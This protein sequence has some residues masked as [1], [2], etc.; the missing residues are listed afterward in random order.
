M[1]SRLLLLG[2]LLLAACASHEPP[3]PLDRFLAGDLDAMRE[4]FDREIR[5]GNANSG[6][7]YLNQLAGMELLDGRLESARKKF[8]AAGRFMNNDN[9]SGSEEF[10]AIWGAESS[11]AW[12]GDPYEKAM[13]GY[14][15]GILYW[16]ADQPDNGRA[17]FRRGLNA[18]SE[19]EG[20]KFQNDFALLFWLAG[21]ASVRMG[22]RDD[23]EAYFRQASEAQVFAVTHGA[24]GNPEARI[25]REPARGNLICLVDMGLGP[26]KY[27]D[28]SDGELARFRARRRPEAQAEVFLGGQSLGRTE[29]LVDVPYQA[30]TRGGTAMEG[31][32]KGKAVFKDLATIGGIVAISRGL[33]TNDS[34]ARNTSIG[35][36]IGLLALSLL[37]R[38]EAD[39]RHWTT[40]PDTVQVLAAEVPP[41]R[42]VLRIEF[43]DAFGNVLSGL[44]QE[45]TVEVPVSGEGVYYF[46]SLPGIDR[47]AALRAE[48]PVGTATEV[49]S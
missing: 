39:V 20:E 46:R 32:R 23:A 47:R 25:L 41:G 10:A 43:Q 2:T 18:D 31:I 14:Y 30:A 3:V 8:D 16:M 19:S 12:R 11:K 6:A 37:T 44:T 28:G 1:A 26:E 29:I 22:L 9:V 49:K 13:N 15:T 35:I 27:P 4:F 7:L 34:S 45:W 33:D 36:G 21:R 48:A 38:A 40:L 24:R 42:H 5:A 17:A